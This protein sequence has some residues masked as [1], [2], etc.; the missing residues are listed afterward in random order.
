MWGEKHYQ[1]KNLIKYCKYCWIHY[2]K[3][4]EKSQSVRK[5]KTGR[6]GMQGER[7]D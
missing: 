4:T 3:V 5:R 7:Q 2:F 6:I 1:E